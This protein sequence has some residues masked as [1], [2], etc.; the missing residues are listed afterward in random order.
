MATLL[1]GFFSKNHTGMLMEYTL[2]SLKRV[3][4]LVKKKVGFRLILDTIFF[5]FLLF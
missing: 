2:T 3:C 1:Y 4:S 5:V